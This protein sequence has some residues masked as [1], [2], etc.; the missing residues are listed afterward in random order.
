MGLARSG[1]TPHEHSL[2]LEFPIPSSGHWPWCWSKQ[3]I[4]VKLI[5][6]R[7]LRK[8]LI[9]EVKKKNSLDSSSV[10]IIDFTKGFQKL[11]K[12]I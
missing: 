6:W 3:H 7:T 1:S 9:M 4:P 2:E 11:N 5:G 10:K 12:K 8:K